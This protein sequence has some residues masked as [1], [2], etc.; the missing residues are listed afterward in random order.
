MGMDGHAHSFF[1]REPD[2]HHPKRVKVR[3]ADER[4]ARWSFEARTSSSRFR[5]SKNRPAPTPVFVLSIRDGV[6]K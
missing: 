4:H 2:P 5:A 1:P 6:I 3:I